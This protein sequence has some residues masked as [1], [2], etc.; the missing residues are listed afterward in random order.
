MDMQP[1]DYLIHI[2]IQSAKQL[3]L[4]DESDFNPFIQCKILGKSKCTNAKRNTSKMTFDEH[5]FFEFKD[6]K[7]E[8]LIDSFITL[9]AENKG[10][11]KRDIIG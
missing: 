11:F 1:G 8:E 10:F 5:L 4:D 3:I 2:H 6:L 7:K 9:S